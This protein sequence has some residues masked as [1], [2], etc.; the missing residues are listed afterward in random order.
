MFLC[1]EQG[2]EFAFLHIG[3]TEKTEK[4]RSYI[5]ILTHAD[6]KKIMEDKP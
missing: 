5:Y 2:L 6:F 3:V 4:C 1:R